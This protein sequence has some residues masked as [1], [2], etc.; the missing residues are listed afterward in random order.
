MADDMQKTVQEYQNL[1]QQLQIVMMQRQQ[2]MVQQ[3]ELDAAL[4]ELEKSSGQAY[5]FIGSVLVAKGKAQLTEDL[6]KDKAE[7]KAREEFLERQEKKLTER[8]T[9]VRKKVEEYA[10]A[11]QGALGG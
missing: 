8:F 3:K 9:A 4:A 11:Q 2:M 5:R 10:K 6:G 7:M 1:Q